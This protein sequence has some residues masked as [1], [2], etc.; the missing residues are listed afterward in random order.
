MKNKD[1]YPKQARI[2]YAGLIML[3]VAWIQLGLSYLGLYDG[4]PKSLELTPLVLFVVLLLGSIIMLVIG[5]FAL[6]EAA[7][8]EKEQ[9]RE[10]EH[11]EQ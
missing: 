1:K 6:T 11:D 4:L 3:A 5:N 7:R 10:D 2:F 8:R 9:E